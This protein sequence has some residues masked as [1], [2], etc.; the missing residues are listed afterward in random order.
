MLD[1]DTLRIDVEQPY[2]GTY[3]E[4]IERCRMEMAGGEIPALKKELKVDLS[5]YDTVFLGYPIWFGTYAPAHSS[6]DKG[7]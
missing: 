3:Q 2:D 4:T 1:A 6:P 5:R 7:I